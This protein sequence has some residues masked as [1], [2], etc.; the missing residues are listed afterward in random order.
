MRFLSAMLA[1]GLGATTVAAV[2]ED[3]IEEIVDREWP[4]SGAPGLAWA[5]VSDGE[6][7]SM[8]ARGVVDRRGDRAVTPDTPF[9]IGS[10]SKSFTAL[11]VMQLVEA[12]RIDL[13][14]PVDTHL[15]P[16]TGQPSAAITI[17]QLLSHTSGYSTL[18][19]NQPFDDDTGGADVLARRVDWLATHEAPASPPG[20]HWQYSNANY[21]VLGRLVEVVSGQDFQAYVSHNILEPL[22]MADSTVADG[23]VHQAMATGHRPWFGAKRPL[24]DH[25]TDRLGAPQGGVI[26]SASDLARYLAVMMNGQDD[27]LSATGKAAMMRPASE[28]SPFYGLGWFVNT[29]NGTVWHSGSTPGVETL[30]T[31]IPAQRKGVVVLVNAGS[32][33]GF[34][35]TAPLRDGITARALGLD[36]EAP[37]SRWMQKL[38]FLTL[39]LA[40]LAFLLSMAW[41]WRKRDEIRA[42]TGVFGQFSLW[43]PLLAMLGMAWVFFGLVPIL[44]GVSNQTLHLFQPDLGLAMQA[45]AVTGVAWALF[46]LAVAYSGKPRA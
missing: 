42:K 3:T 24:G 6:P 10:I 43:F 46:R 18:Q 28:A 11:A 16:F 5:M 17:R 19:G 33:I 21:Q 8:G 7:G 29:G 39:A 9:L 30:A 2:P 12:G 31:M 45:T 44:F 1:L 37:G 36:Q 20:T 40:P 41:A 38:T 25:R 32:G 34:G 35:E 14:D 22:G 23:E 15:D 26:A 4:A 27:V 13:D